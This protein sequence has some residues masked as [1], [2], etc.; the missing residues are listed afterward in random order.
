MTLKKQELTQKIGFNIRKIRM[1]KGL[2]IKAL[3]FEADI[4][5]TQV[6]RIERGKINT[7]IYQIYLIAKALGVEYMALFEKI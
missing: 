1:S 6:S 7:S 2:S 3:A 4:E 5:Y